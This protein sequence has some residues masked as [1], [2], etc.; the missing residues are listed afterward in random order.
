[1]SIA[2]DRKRRAV[3]YAN[4][5][6]LEQDAE[7]LA[8][9]ETRTVGK[10]SKGQIFEHIARTM[11]GTVDGFSFKFPLPV[12]LVATLILKRWFLTKGLP[13]GVKLRKEAATTLIPEE[14]DEVLALTHLKQAIERLKTEPKRA[15]SPLFGQLSRAESDQMQLR[16]AEL[17]MSHLIPV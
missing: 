8:S 4:L 12:R 1:M 5:S 9:A 17:H 16:H 13:T 2:E 7:R 10:W 6:E 11:D 14:A 15:P 3:R